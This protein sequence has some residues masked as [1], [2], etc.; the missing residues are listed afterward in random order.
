MFKK[1]SKSRRVGNIVSTVFIIMPLLMAPWW[2]MRALEKDPAPVTTPSVAPS[3]S[4]TPVPVKTWEELSRSDHRYVKTVWVFL[5]R[6]TAAGDR[7]GFTA[8]AET[9][10][11]R[12]SLGCQWAVGG[13]IADAEDTAGLEAAQAAYELA[14]SRVETTKS[15]TATVYFPPSVV[16]TYEGRYPNGRAFLE[17]TPR[18]AFMFMVVVCR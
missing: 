6:Y 4:P 17:V 18:Y 2:V 15:F 13:S 3:A 5:R 8:L 11:S 12:E 9:H 16:P 1:G 7:E 14:R 10:Q